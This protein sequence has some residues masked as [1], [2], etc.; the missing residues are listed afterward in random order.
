MLKVRYP[1]AF[2]TNTGVSGVDN[3]SITMNAIESRSPGSGF[4]YGYVV[5][6]ASS[7]IMVGAIG[8]N[9]AFG[10]F[11]KPLLDEFGWTRA[12]TSGAVSFSW[13]IQ[14]FLAVVMG[15]LTDRLGPRL[16][17]TVA[18]VLLGSG[19]MLMSQ[20]NE[21]WQLYL[22]WGVLAGA[23]MS[24]VY[25][26]L[27]TTI[28]RWFIARR[29]AM[30]GIVVGSVGIGTLAGP[31]VANWLISTY[32]WRVSFLTLGVA[33]F[34]IMLVAAQFLK[35]QPASI[36]P[37]PRGEIQSSQQTNA[38]GAVLKEAIR[39]LQ[40]WMV[41]GLF[42]AFGFCLFAVMIH[43]VPNSIDLGIDAAAAA[44]I[45]S[46]IGGIS[47]V[48]KVIL[49]STGDRTGS[50]SVY[51]ISF[52]LMAVSMLWLMLSKQT[53]ML[54][55]FAVVFGLAYGGCATSQSPIVAQL[56]GLRSHGLI[57]GMVNNGFTL[58]AT[59]G[60]FVAGYIF[61]VSNSYSLAFLISAGIAVIG[62][63]CSIAIKPI[64]K[65]AT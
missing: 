50:R 36:G 21:L 34:V 6:I 13:A 53:W 54:Y 29:G 31:L 55:L 62:L 45:I 18:A 1:E 52:S 16:V 4:Y 33:V 2:T 25:I 63:A 19:Y 39:T 26:P 44:G 12:M 17:L 40:F 3:Q 64:R 10:V 49:G 37:M 8:V 59:V 47:I 5:V 15:I 9:Y 38:Q 24:G 28:A 43:V 61:D 57:F 11:F 51:I 42:F 58:G 60:P 22:F 41:F 23:G 35:R 46:A 20:I 27:N 7:L 48:S 32:D 65:T 30:T 56:F 14:G